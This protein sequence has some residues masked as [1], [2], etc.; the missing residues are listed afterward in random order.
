MLPSGYTIRI[1]IVKVKLEG[2]LSYYSLSG[3]DDF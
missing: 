3:N 1:M 2:K